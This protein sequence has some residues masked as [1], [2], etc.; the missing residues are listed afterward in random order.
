MFREN[1]LGGT[2]A[3]TVTVSPLT[4]DE[5]LPLCLHEHGERLRLISR[6]L[7]ALRRQNGAISADLVSNLIAEVSDPLEEE[8]ER[9]EALL[10]SLEPGQHFKEGQPRDPGD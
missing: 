9:I 1:A 6:S 4:L 7:F 10:E 2:P 5:Q 8:I 3:R